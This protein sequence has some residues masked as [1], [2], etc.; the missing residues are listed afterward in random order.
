MPSKT[1]ALIA[2]PLAVLMVTCARA[3]T[4]PDREI[5]ITNCIAQRRA[6][7]IKTAWGEARRWDDN[8]EL[9]RDACLRRYNYPAAAPPTDPRLRDLEQRIRQLE[10]AQ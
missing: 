3:E 2:L 8:D 5:E 4:T 1:T 6:P 10:D 7:P 9:H